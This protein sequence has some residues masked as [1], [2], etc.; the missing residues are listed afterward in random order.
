MKRLNGEAMSQFERRKKFGARLRG[1]GFWGTGDDYRTP[2][3]PLRRDRYRLRRAALG[4]RGV[5]GD[6]KGGEADEPRWFKTALLATCISAVEKLPYSLRRERQIATPR[7]FGAP[8]HAMFACA[9][10]ALGAAPTIV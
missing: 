4:R 7:D 6:A 3:H 9:E 10:I 8:S 1:R 5:L 2:A